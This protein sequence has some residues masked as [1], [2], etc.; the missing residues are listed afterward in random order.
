MRQR[1]PGNNR[2]RVNYVHAPVL[3]A[4][5]DDEGVSDGVRGGV[6][7]IGSLRLGADDDNPVGHV[8]D[9]NPAAQAGHRLGRVKALQCALKDR[10]ATGDDGLGRST[11]G[12]RYHHDRLADWSWRILRGVRKA[13]EGAHHDKRAGNCRLA[14][15]LASL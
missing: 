4:F 1:W 8:G 14:E 7:A 6:C 12:R 11:G 5:V 2:R 15:H 9:L 13:R 10:V 3:L